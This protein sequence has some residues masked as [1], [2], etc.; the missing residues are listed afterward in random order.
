M[1]RK[2]IEEYPIENPKYF[3]YPYVAFGTIT[4]FQGQAGLGKTTIWSK[5]FAEASHGLY[6]PRLH[7]R[8]IKARSVLTEWQLAAI[9]NMRGL[10]SED[11]IV[12]ENIVREIV[13]GIE[14]DGIDDDDYELEREQSIP[15]DRPFMRF[16]GDPIKIVYISRENSYGNIIRKKYEEFGGLPGYLTVIDESD[17]IRF[18]T[19]EDNI[20]YITGDAKLV[21]IDPIFTFM[22]GRLGDNKD[23]TVALENFDAVARE[24]NA[25]YVLINNL[26]KN[27]A[28]IDM[29]RG[30]GGSNLKNIARSLFKLDKEGNIVFI[31]GLKNNNAP[32][33]GRIGLLFDSIGRPDFINYKQLEDALKEEE[34][35]N[36]EAINGKQL[37]RAVQ[38]LNQKFEECDTY[39]HNEIKDM[40][41]AEGISL[42]TLNRAKKIAGIGS[43]KQGSVDSKWVKMGK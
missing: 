29:D 43:D 6:P 12:S 36:E 25:A 30:L 27:G 2:T 19:T 32:Y 22:D 9:D 42:S 38:F 23:V 37:E 15:M 14:V 40:A 21:V 16:R 31:E 1:I 34:V 35:R 18:K 39:D 7:K 13:N 28:S 8:T 41:F 17:K 11:D 3:W 20:R 4:V 5:I 24:T 26:T 33:H 10:S